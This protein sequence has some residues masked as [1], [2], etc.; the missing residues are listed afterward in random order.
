MKKTKVIKDNNISNTLEKKLDSIV[1][2]QEEIKNSLQTILMA[3]YDNAVVLRRKHK[4]GSNVKNIAFLYQDIQKLNIALYP[5]G[6]SKE[7]YQLK[8]EF[9]NPII[10]AFNPN[11]K[12][13][14][15]NEQNS[16]EL[17]EKL[18]NQVFDITT[19]NNTFDGLIKAIGNK[20]KKNTV[21]KAIREYLSEENYN[22][23]PLEE[24]EGLFD[25]DGNLNKEILSGYKEKIF[26]E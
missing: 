20:K 1:I 13:K 22:K 19:K 18:F 6:N 5:V 23:L 9:L 15:E 8:F 4:T 25:K 24:W 14:N 7:N 11:E 12:D 3:I 2:N 10:K 21:L 17:I 16:K 26:G